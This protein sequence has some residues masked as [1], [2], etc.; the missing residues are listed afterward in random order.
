MTG[1]RPDI[2][3]ALL[4]PHDLVMMIEPSQDGLACL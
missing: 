1:S 2:S 3:S 4:V